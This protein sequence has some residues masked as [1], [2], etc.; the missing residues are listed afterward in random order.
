[1]VLRPS[2]WLTRLSSIKDQVNLTVEHEMRQRVTGFISTT[3]VTVSL[4]LNLWRKRS[5][6]LIVIMTQTLGLP[7]F[8]LYAKRNALA[9]SPQ[10]QGSL[11]RINSTFSAGSRGSRVEGTVLECCRLIWP[12]NH[13]L[14]HQRP[15][16][17]TMERLLPLQWYW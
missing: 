6:I 15:L 16:R 1:M 7:E 17:P 4:S 9:L 14:S 8:W 11:I 12:E 5:L 3:V 13:S 10:T 2:N